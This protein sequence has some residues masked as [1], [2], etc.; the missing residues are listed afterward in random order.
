MS[1]TASLGKILYKTRILKKNGSD[2]TLTSNLDTFL[3]GNSTSF[4]LKYFVNT[5]RPT[6]DGLNTSFTDKLTC[7]KTLT[8]L[9]KN[10][11]KGLYTLFT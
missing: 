5:I 10:F 1:Q 4:S 7:I 9:P 6:T 11:V 3:K 8:Y 2:I